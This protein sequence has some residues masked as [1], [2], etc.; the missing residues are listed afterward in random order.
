[1]M[2]TGTAKIMYGKKV[3]ALVKIDP[4]AEE[5]YAEKYMIE[6]FFIHSNR[7][8]AVARNYP[9]LNIAVLRLIQKQYKKLHSK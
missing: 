4:L 6:K 2:A 7:Y 9:R 5:K 3:V 1:F 8:R